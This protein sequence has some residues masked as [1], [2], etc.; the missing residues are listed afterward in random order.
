VAVLSHER[1]RR[2]TPHLD[3]ALEMS[4]E[5]RAGY[6]AELRTRDPELAGDLERLLAQRSLGDREGFLEGGPP[7]PPPRPSLAGQTFGAY[8][9]LT[10]VGQGGMGSVW[11]ARRSDGRFEGMTAVK[12][13]NASLVGRAG[14]ER[15]RREGSIL[16]RLADPHI[17]RLLDA[18]VSPTGQPFLV[19]E[20]VEGEPIDR[21]CDGLRLGIEARIRL[22]LGVLGAVAH[23]H[24]NLV[25]HRDIKPSNVL[26]GRDGQA[27][28]LEDGVE[29]ETTALTREGGRALTPE[30]AAPEQIVGGSVTTATDVYALGTL[31]YLLLTGRHPVAAP[32]PS[33]GDL[34]RAIL[35]TEPERASDLF[36]GS[37]AFSPEEQRRVAEA[38]ATTPDALRRALQGDLDTI[39][40]KAL[41]KNAAERYPSV[42]ALAEDLRRFL[43]DEPIG[44]TPDTLGY[45][46][47][48]FVRRHRAGVAAAAVV[49]AAALLGT[50]GI[51]WQARAAR[52]ERDDARL[53]LARATAVK[54]FLGF[55]LSAAAPAGRPYSVNELLEQGEMVIDREFAA[56][57]PLR[58]EMLAAIAQ[59]HMNAE[60][61]EKAARILERS[62]AIAEQARDPVLRA[63][64]L[65][66]LAVAKLAT[67]GNTAESR[68]MIFRALADL[69]GDPR[70]APVRA[71]CLT[72]RAS[73]GFFTEDGDAMVR[74]A[75]DAIALL[76]TGP[77]QNLSAQ[78]DARSALAFGYYLTRQ[79]SK[80]E[81]TYAEV[82]SALERA[83]RA[84]TLAASDIWNNWAVLY[85]VGDIRKAEP[86]LRRSL[87]LRRSIEGD[88]AV[89]PTY[90]FN[91]AG[92]LHRLA[93]YE[94]AERVFRETIRMARSRQSR[95][96]LEATMELAD[97]YTERGDI[98]AAEKQLGLLEPHLGRTY[99]NPLR[100]ALLAYSRGVLALRRGE[101]ARAREELL[102]STRLFDEVKA[103]LTQNVFAL[104][105]L[106]RAEAA[107][108]N[109]Q[110]AAAAAGRAVA[111]AESQ[112]EPG[113][114]SYLV[115]HSKAVLGEVQLAAGNRSGARVTLAAALDHLERTLGPEH[116]A[117]KKSLQ[118]A[119]S[120]D[121]GS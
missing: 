62:A 2:L 65:C 111:L 13:L 104:I 23:A 39:L 118:L 82:V 16:A 37:R 33:P 41:K 113:A 106:A 46:A 4:P 120:L 60:R 54:D 3:R 17:A 95:V 11:L 51:V 85:F 10:L 76:E 52:R 74:D 64:A 43:H 1:W 12:L 108:G 83:G 116:P 49:A 58:A 89:A 15:F 70:F 28:F 107:L 47:A 20:Y 40:G 92:V 14:E 18:G 77:V 80:A 98:L 29:G 32:R 25:V 55:L 56:D 6:V 8:T 57:Q 53:Q 91:Y 73:F 121:A 105:G 97:V 86:L 101:P 26:V 63:R 103:R 68:E 31:L 69:P 67:D 35:E 99:F 34:V 44:A 110:A 59:Q 19:L 79:Y 84:R 96:E 21:Y 87:E 48:K 117:T 5:A 50:V 114:P 36:G 24:A 75:V 71:E 72:Q 9:L 7:L 38:R 45:R 90:L 109:G 100:R 78:I 61:F 88:D 27:K 93:R 66:P 102:A 115:G 22:F 94:D 81:K 30:F 119:A 42:T 112:I